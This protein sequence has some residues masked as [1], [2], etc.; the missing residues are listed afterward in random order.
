MKKGAPR[1][2]MLSKET[3][4]NLEDGSMRGV[5]GASLQPDTCNA[6]CATDV[7]CVTCRGLACQTNLS[8]CC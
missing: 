3:L 1:K 5:V 8:N 6:S 4:R 7:T 2:M